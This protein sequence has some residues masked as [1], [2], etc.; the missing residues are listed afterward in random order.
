MFVLTQEEISRYYESLCK[1]SYEQSFP[2]NP[3]PENIEKYVNVRYADAEILFCLDK[4]Y[5]AILNLTN[6]IKEK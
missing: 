1:R 2:N 4:L 6:I 3:I 5:N